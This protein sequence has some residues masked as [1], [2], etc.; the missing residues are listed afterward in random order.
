METFENR[1][2]IIFMAKTV[3]TTK[4][5]NAWET[6]MNPLRS[7]TSNQ[8]EFMLDNAKHGND[9]RLQ[10]AFFQ[11]ERTTPIFSVCIQKRIS[12]VLGRKWKIVPIDEK[13]NESVQ[14]A[15]EVQKIMDECD[16]LNEDGLTEAIRHLCMATFRGR[17]VLK[18]FIEKGRLILKKLQNWNVLEYN[19]KLYWN[20][21]VDIGHLPSDG[22]LEEI[23][24][25]EVA[26]IRED[27]PIDIPGIQIYL[28]QLVGEQQWAR[29]VEK[30]GIPQVLI[31]A[32]EGT[33]DTALDLW[34]QRAQQIFEGGSGVLPPGA[35]IDEL[36]AARGQDPFS[37]FVKHQ[38][39]MISIL[40]T[41]GSL[42]TIG[43]STGLGS[44]L[45]DVQ[46]D[47]FQMLVS[48]DCKRI[49]NVMSSVVVSKICR[50]ILVQ[51]VLCRFSFL[52]DEEITSE[53]YLEMAQKLVG[54]NV[55]I[56]LTEFKKLTGISFIK[57]GTEDESAD[58]W[59]PD[60]NGD[61]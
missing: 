1:G 4:A 28:R 41:G 13:S 37:E 52:E 43:G 24:S 12:G 60:K 32:P 61:E 10:T 27:F 48:Q 47:Q 22:K 51:D 59:T 18:P 2:I 44:N 19:G 7:L 29:F 49:S 8:I 25:G 50:E 20:P 35:K 33:P 3:K 53:Q 6:F 11:M 36:T 5:L 58:L 9:V 26:C 16:R 23:P 54:M 34:S 39:E 42:A 15:E 57:D 30:Q 31:T 46:N 56:N 14:Q 45:A 55:P 38:S 40:A 21:E 17:S